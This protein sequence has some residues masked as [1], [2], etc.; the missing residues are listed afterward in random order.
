M[1]LCMQLP[2]MTHMCLFSY[3]V[4]SY[5]VF[6]TQMWPYYMSR[7]HLCHTCH[8]ICLMHCTLL[9]ADKFPL[10]HVN[11]QQE[12]VVTIFLCCCK[13]HFNQR[14]SY[15][16]WELCDD[17]ECYNKQSVHAH[18]S[19]KLLSKY[20]E[21]IEQKRTSRMRIHS[22]VMAVCNTWSVVGFA[23][24]GSTSSVAVQMLCKDNRWVR[25]II[26]WSVSMP[27]WAVRIPRN[28]ETGRT[29]HDAR[30]VF[31]KFET[32]IADHPQVAAGWRD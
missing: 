19:Q 3:Y 8:A 24:S 10:Q 28:C 6:S 14:S 25:Q 2:H 4:G 27:S 30:S 1:V 12:F 22:K 20:F 5:V 32:R 7:V 18:A 9:H 16:D 17:S 23:P 29:H 15:V 26:S 11:M 13:L 21:K 31:I